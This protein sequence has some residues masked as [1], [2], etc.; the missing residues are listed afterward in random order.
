MK[1]FEH[2]DYLKMDDLLTQEQ[3]KVR[4]TVRSF[5]QEHVLPVI[6]HHNREGTFPKELIKPMG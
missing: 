5:V 6:V 1:P 2:L 4:E 3:R